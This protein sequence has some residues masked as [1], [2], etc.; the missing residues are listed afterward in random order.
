MLTFFQV[1]ADQKSSLQ[2][3]NKSQLLPNC[4][5]FLTVR[6]A[7]IPSVSRF[8]ILSVSSIFCCH[9]LSSALNLFLYNHMY[10]VWSSVFI[11]SDHRTDSMSNSCDAIPLPRSFQQLLSAYCPKGIFIWLIFKTHKFSKFAFHYQSTYIQCS[12][13]TLL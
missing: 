9:H 10:S 11:S 1:S 4:F 7:N 3:C 8:A 2:S 13:A 12:Q 6:L 5:L